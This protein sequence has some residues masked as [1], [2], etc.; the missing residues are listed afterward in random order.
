MA[1]QPTANPTDDP[2]Q[3][4]AAQTP[5][6]QVFSSVNVEPSLLSL[7]QRPPSQATA[8]ANFLKSL[9]TVKPEDLPEDSQGCNICTEPFVHPT[10]GQ[11]SESAVKL[12]CS[13][14]MGSACL[15]KWLEDPIR[16]SCPMCRAVLFSQGSLVNEQ[17][18]ALFVDQLSVAVHL[19]DTILT[20]SAWTQTRLAALY[21]AAESEE[22]RAEI[23]RI[24]QQTTRL[25]ELLDMLEGKIRELGWFILRLLAQS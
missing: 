24:V 4:E 16:N 11:D 9:P 13:H 3:P 2:I 20:E 12:P 25:D 23:V 18:R 21:N 22:R 6:A 19:L 5:D 7:L 8:L 14:I 15:A 1:E 10:A 17:P